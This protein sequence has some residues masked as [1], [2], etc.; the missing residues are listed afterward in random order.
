MPNVTLTYIRGW[1]QMVYQHMIYSPEIKNKHDNRIIIHS[2]WNIVNV[3][4]HGKAYLQVHYRMLTILTLF[5]MGPLRHVWLF[6]P[7][8]ACSM[9]LLTPALLA[10]NCLSCS[11]LGGPGPPPFPPPGLT[12]FPSGSRHHPTSLS[13]TITFTYIFLKMHSYR[14]HYNS[15]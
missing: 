3:S 12:P 2:V 5:T 9:R 4:L 11:L 6:F 8:S 13:D 15:T 7:S 14:P 10:V 1:M